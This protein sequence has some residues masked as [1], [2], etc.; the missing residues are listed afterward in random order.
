MR[1][2]V[3]G[4][5]RHTW[6]R[7]IQHSGGWRSL[8]GGAQGGMMMAALHARNGHGHARE[9]CQC[10]CVHQN[11]WWYLWKLRGTHH[12]ILVHSHV[13]AQC[14]VAWSS[15]VLHC[16]LVH[17]HLEALAQTAGA[18]LVAVCLV[19]HAEALFLRLADVLAGATD[20]ALEEARTAVAGI[21]AVVFAGA[22]VAANLAGYMVQD[23][24]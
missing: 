10:S 14:G 17:A 13:A 20:A 4:V 5:M 16:I 23:A 12:G 21:D 9:T 1:A 6:H 8:E 11:L 2:L 15:F 22:V 24:A 7:E 19:H 3:N 18:A